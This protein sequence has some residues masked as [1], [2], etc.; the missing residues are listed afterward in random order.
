MHFRQKLRDLNSSRGEP[1]NSNK[2][3]LVHNEPLPR[4][5]VTA[6]LWRK[7][8]QERAS[9]SSFPPPTL[10]CRRPGQTPHKLRACSHSTSSP[11]PLRASPHRPPPFSFLHR[12]HRAL[13]RVKERAHCG[14]IPDLIWISQPTSSWTRLGHALTAPTGLGLDRREESISLHQSFTHPEVGEGE[15]SSTA[16]EVELSALIH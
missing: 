10:L 7:R 2:G 5:I 11:A 15:E 3:W 14:V 8:H 9:F 1:R 6:V 4:A 12:T 13:L 16:M